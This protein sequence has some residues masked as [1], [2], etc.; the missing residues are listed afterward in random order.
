MTGHLVPGPDP[1]GSTLLT[2]PAVESLLRA[3]VDHAGGHL[4]SWRLDHVDA[5]PGLSTTATYL[6]TVTW[7]YGTRSELLGVSARSSG[8]ATSDG[9]AEIFADGD[10]EV[11]VWLYPNDPDL[12][13]LARA[14]YPDRMAELITSQ[15]LVGRP[16]SPGQVS[17][18]MIGYRPRRRAV[19]RVDVTD[20]RRTFYVKV[21][22]GTLFADVLHRHRILLDAGVPAPEIAGT[23]DDNLLILAELPGRPLARAVFD[24]VEPCTAANLIGVLDTMPISV[25]ALERR[26][27]WSEAVNHYVQM[28]SAAMP[29]QAGR[30][31]WMSQ[32][33]GQGLSAIP[34]GEE[35]THGDF[36]EGQVH[37]A[38]GRV[39]GILDVDTI[40]PGRR[41]DDLACMVAHL[42]T[43]QRMDAQQASRL[44]HL[45]RTWVPVFDERVDPTELRLRAAAVIISLATGPYRSQEPHWEH[46]TVMILDAAEA[47][48]RQVV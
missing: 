5:N 48:V 22:R 31:A 33:I 6:A 37:V 36:H 20:P 9:N 14:A 44:H 34:R 18:R 4:D 7:S 42:S 2:T 23:T 19:V 10:R 28:V 39:C 24:P 12:P 27:P 15:G 41:A 17:L 26:P 29:S 21:L 47:L 8:P 11:A 45:I 43:I 25:A 40:G 13:G 3:A 30:L 46:E 35:A 38:D 1:D 16:V 32:T